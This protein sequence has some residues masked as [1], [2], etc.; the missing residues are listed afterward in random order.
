VADEKD[1]AD[2]W[3]VVRV[4]FCFVP[5][6]APAP[7]EWMARHPGWFKI[8]ATF[9]PR[10]SQPSEPEPAAPKGIPPGCPAYGAAAA[11][12]PARATTTARATAAL[13]ASDL[14]QGQGVH[15]QEGGGQSRDHQ[16]HP[17]AGREQRRHAWARVRHEVPNAGADHH[18]PDG[19]RCRL[20]ARPGSRR[21]WQ[22]ARRLFGSWPERPCCQGVCGTAR[23]GCHADPGAAASAV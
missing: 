12:A 20:G 10:S 13:R 7:T 21:R 23:Q 17:L 15:L 2:G 6:G 19:H 16:A 3:D 18:R 14:A 9:V 8:P 1:W 22:A 5:H 4:P 11:G